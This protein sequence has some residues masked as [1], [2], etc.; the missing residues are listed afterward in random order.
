[1]TDDYLRS[2]WTAFATGMGESTYGPGSAASQGLS[3][4]SSGEPQPGSLRFAHAGPSAV[5][6]GFNDGFLLLNGYRAS[7]HHIG[8]TFVNTVGHAAMWDMNGGVGAAP[9]TTQW[10][11]RTISKTTT[12]NAS[13]NGGTG[14]INSFG[15]TYAGIPFVWVGSSATNVLVGLTTKSGGVNP[16]ISTGTFAST[17]SYIGASDGSRQANVSYYFLSLGT[18]AIT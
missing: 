18:V 7:L 9:L 15:V 2:F 5:V 8:T 1:M 17:W 16:D 10:V 4:A 12:L 3:A 13:M 6:G 14:F 11:L